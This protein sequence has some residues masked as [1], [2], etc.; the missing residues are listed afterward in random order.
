M[1]AS[2]VAALLGAGCND[3]CSAYPAVSG[4]AMYVDETPGLTDGVY[5]WTVTSDGITR[6]RDV[7]VTNGVGRCECTVPQPGDPSS[8]LKIAEL[9]ITMDKNQAE[10]SLLDDPI[11]SGLTLP[12][13]IE[14]TLARGT[15][16]IAHFAFDPEYKPVHGD[17]QTTMRA[18]YT[19]GVLGS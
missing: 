2:C 13:H 18:D 15:Q 8:A 3:Y 10:V 19:V 6:T 5:T 16:T 17:C 7:T 1:I 11:K 9:W 14:V 4:V 12:K